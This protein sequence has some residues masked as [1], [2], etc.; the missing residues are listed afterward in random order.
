MNSRQA[1]RLLEAN[2]APPY[3]VLPGRLKLTKKEEKPSL[4]AMKIR[5]LRGASPVIFLFL[6]GASPFQETNPPPSPPTSET[7]IAPQESPVEKP[8]SDY[9][10]QILGRK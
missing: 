6:L 8:N 3:L 2:P 4:K 5:L 7:P 9:M 1:S 10:R